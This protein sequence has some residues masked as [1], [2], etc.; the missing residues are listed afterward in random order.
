MTV[1][2]LGRG[3]SRIDPFAWFVLL[4]LVAGCYGNTEHDG[5]PAEPDADA[6]ADGAPDDSADADGTPDGDADVEPDGE[7]WCP[8]PIRETCD[9]DLERTLPLL[10]EASRFGDGF[11][12]TAL[13]WRSMIGERT[14]GAETVIV[15]V[16]AESEFPAEW[17][18]AELVVAAASAL[19]PRGASIVSAS[20]LLPNGLVALLC[21]GDGCAL[22]GAD[23]VPGSVVALAPWTNGEVPLTQPVRGLWIPPVG[24]L[25][26]AFG[27]GMSCF[28]GSAWTTVLAEG[29][30]APALNDAAGVGNAA[31]VVG[32]LGRVASTGW[33]AWDDGWGLAYPDFVTV[34]FDGEDWLVGTDEG[35][36]AARPERLPSCRIADEAIFALD[37]R[38]YGGYLDGVTAS[39]RIFV[40]SGSLSAPLGFCYTGQDVGVPVGATHWTC[41]ISDNRVVLAEDALYGSLGCAV[42]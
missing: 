7:S 37:N 21:D 10:V 8:G 28:D 11:R 14:A 24:D 1:R 26:C 6:D 23:A 41:G 22:Y 29:A 20:G 18:T 35:T 31:V 17:N 36:I 9:A 4:L 19:H 3:A 15:A 5:C 32:D 38:P 40:G 2:R 16:D 27:Y 12:F 33:P 34:A 39:G 42:E 13:G 25:V 30:G